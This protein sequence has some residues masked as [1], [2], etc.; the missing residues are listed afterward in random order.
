MESASFLLI[1]YAPSS[2]LDESALK[3]APFLNVRTIFTIAGMGK[4]NAAIF[5]RIKWSNSG[6]QIF[7]NLHNFVSAPR[8]KFCIIVLF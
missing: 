2:I 4:I 3:V 5:A 8:A 1:K 7:F 6:K